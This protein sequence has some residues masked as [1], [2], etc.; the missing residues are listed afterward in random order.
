MSTQVGGQVL[1]Q[2]KELVG[3]ATVVHDTC[4]PVQ[5]PSPITITQQ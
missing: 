4:S 2:A 3:T 5:E 1:S